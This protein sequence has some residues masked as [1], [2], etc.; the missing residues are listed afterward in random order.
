MANFIYQCSECHQKTPF[1][2]ET[3]VCPLC[4][5]KQQKD[6]PLR[7]VLDLTFDEL[8]I[9]KERPLPFQFLPVEE[10]Y[11]PESPVGFT[12]MWE[13]TR[14]RDHLGLSSLWVKDEISQPTGSLKDR[15]SFLVAAMAKKHGIK[16]IALASTGNAGSSMAGI[17]ANSGLKVTLFLPASAPP[18]KLAQ[19]LQYG[20]QVFLVDG[21][22]DLAYDLSLE[23]SQKN[24]HIL[25][26]NTA[27]NP[28]TIEGKKTASIEIVDQL[29][30]IVPDHIFIG[31]GDGVILSGLYKGL[32]DLKQVG[33]IS[34]IPTIHA[35]QSEKSNALYQAW[36]NGS[37]T[38]I[39][40]IAY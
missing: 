26:R 15:A 4:S 21:N 19:A 38:K 33:L 6:E 1:V 34:D 29:E 23:Y 20:A 7:G 37:F 25:S 16:E 5:K 24:P 3:M 40:A 30:G 36:K 39:N 9:E 8:T 13:S 31:T 22:Y 11:F 28:L 35:V 27:Y 2:P 17:G 32:L 12:P 14:L 10:E 18:A